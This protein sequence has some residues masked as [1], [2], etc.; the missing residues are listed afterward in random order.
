MPFSDY[1]ANAN[2]NWFKGT[3]FVAAP[4]GNV[5]VSL[6]SESPTSSGSV[7]DV[8]T[9]IAGGRATLPIANLSSPTAATGGG[10]QISN[11]ASISVTN[12]ATSTATVTY[13]GIWS[14]AT[15][16][17]FLA[18]GLLT[19]PVNVL[20]GDILQFATGQLVIRGI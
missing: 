1:L 17:N 20:P 14:A 16:G 19:T 15:G 2:L 5:F 13:F 3:S 7:G 11:T 9:A 4:S 18:Y 8:T 10:R 12:S 6:H